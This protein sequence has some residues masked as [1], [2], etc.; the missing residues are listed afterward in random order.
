MSDMR[1]LGSLREELGA[2]PEPEFEM[3]LP[4]GWV[5]R[6]PD[7]DTEREFE[8]AMR[9]RAMKQSAPQ[10]L[11]N[12]RRMLRESFAQMRDNRVVAMFMPF[13]DEDR[14]YFPV[15]MSVLATVRRGTPDQPLD[16]YVRHL[17]ANEGGTPLLEDK[18]VVRVEREER[19]THE[20]TT[21][22][23][24]STV[25]VTPIPGTKRQR[26]LEFVASYGRPEAMKRD[27]PQVVM[28]HGLFDMMISTLRWVPPKQK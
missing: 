1:G 18:R 27:D 28:V 14:G 11:V 10:M 20:G 13:N 4:D 19:Q 23:V 5:R 21:I 15:P 9:R 22:V 12:G 25:Y 7:A 6:A 24:A 26:A 2:A 17:I 16:A 3:R 8:Q